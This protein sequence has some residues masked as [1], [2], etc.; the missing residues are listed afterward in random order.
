MH[1]RQRVAAGFGGGWSHFVPRRPIAGLPGVDEYDGGALGVGSSDT[2]LSYTFEAP[3]TVS[4]I[5]PL[6]DLQGGNTLLEV[7]GTGRRQRD[8][9]LP[10]QVRR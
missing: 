1:L 3:V 6:R 4:N 10:I 7:E 5:A 9:A 8:D 2:D